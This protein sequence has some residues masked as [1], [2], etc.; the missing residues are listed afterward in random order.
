[1]PSIFPFASSSPMSCGSDHWLF[2]RDIK[3]SCEVIHLHSPLTFM[4]TRQRAP[5]NYSN[6]TSNQQQ[7]M[8]STMY[9]AHVAWRGNPGPAFAEEKGKFTGH[10]PPHASATNGL[11][12]IFRKAALGRE[13]TGIDNQLSSLLSGSPFLVNWGGGWG[14]SHSG[15]LSRWRMEI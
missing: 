6:R 11:V 8:G 7:S 1:M 4:H 3:E 2:H 14:N 9:L 5:P 10:I 13:G 12:C 15:E